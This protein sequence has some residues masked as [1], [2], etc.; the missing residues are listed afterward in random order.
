MAKH[1]IGNR[2]TNR[3]TPILRII[4]HPK[5]LYFKEAR[6]NQIRFNKTDSIESSSFKIAPCRQNTNK[7]PQAN[8]KAICQTKA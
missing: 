6:F 1:A 8:T 4:H 7:P 2:R 3:H 5:E